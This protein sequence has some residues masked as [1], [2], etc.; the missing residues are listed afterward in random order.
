MA[1]TNPDRLWAQAR[2]WNMCTPRPV[3]LRGVKGGTLLRTLLVVVPCSR[4]AVRRRQL[5][6]KHGA[7]DESSSVAITSAPPSE[8]MASFQGMFDPNMTYPEISFPPGVRVT[9]STRTDTRTTSLLES[10]SLRRSAAPRS[11][12]AVKVRTASLRRKCAPP[13]AATASRA[14]EAVV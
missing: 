14:D 6:L 2:A 3:R 8:T 7:R 9:P 11:E 13:S 10:R 12:E 1:R 4:L 5:L